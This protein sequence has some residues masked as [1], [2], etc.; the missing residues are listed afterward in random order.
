MPSA[1][2]RGPSS[3]DAEIKE[4]EGDELASMEQ[5]R[6]YLDDDDMISWGFGRP[7]GERG[8]DLEPGADQEW[9]DSQDSSSSSLYGDEMGRRLSH[10]DDLDRDVSAGAGGA[11]SAGNSA[12][13]TGGVG[14]LD[15]T[16]V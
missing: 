9:I 3:L 4:E 5:I 10:E 8:Q 16:G 11:A 15:V 13:N 12:V 14:V 1:P 6:Q 7:R 2:R